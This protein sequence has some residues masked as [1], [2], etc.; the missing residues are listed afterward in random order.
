MHHSLKNITISL[1][2]GAFL[3]GKPDAPKRIIYTLEPVDFWMIM[4]FLKYILLLVKG[5]L[6]NYMERIIN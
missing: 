3:K 1:Y 6:I 5:L 4:H 2:K